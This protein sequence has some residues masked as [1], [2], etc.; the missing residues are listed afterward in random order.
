MVNREKSLPVSQTGRLLHIGHLATGVA[1]GMI[2][3]GLKQAV[4][5]NVPTISDMLLTPSN[6]KRLAD[7]LS[8]MRGAAM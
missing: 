8:V 2:G 4:A 7:K 5:G 6:A 3:E 1:G